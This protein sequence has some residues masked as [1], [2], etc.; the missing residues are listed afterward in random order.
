MGRDRSR[1]GEGSEGREAERRLGAW[2]RW[3][4]RA[5]QEGKGRIWEG[6]GRSESKNG[7]DQ[8]VD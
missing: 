2:R 7:T 1:V 4:R 6:C 5:R 8:Y 3:D